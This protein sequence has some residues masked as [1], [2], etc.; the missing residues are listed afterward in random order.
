MVL[1]PEAF[2]QGVRLKSGLKA[3]GFLSE[4]SKG[5]EGTNEN[6]NLSISDTEG[7]EGAER[8]T[9]KREG[10]EAAE[11]GREG[12]RDFGLVEHSTE[13]SSLPCFGRCLP[14]RSA[15]LCVNNPEAWSG[16]WAAPVAKV[17]LFN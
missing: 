3:H 1:I 16:V 2:L 15:F 9:G 5:R 11:P 17:G 14:V 8:D 7:R 6:T 13:D 4:T 12:E 10:R